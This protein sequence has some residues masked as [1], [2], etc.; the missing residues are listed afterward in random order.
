MSIQL[1]DD[2]AEIVFT[3]CTFGDLVCELLERR[4]QQMRATSAYRRML[5][6][7]H[8]N[9]GVKELHK[10]VDILSQSEKRKLRRIDSVAAMAKF[11][12]SVGYPDILI[13]SSNPEAVLRQLRDLKRQP[14]ISTDQ[15]QLGDVAP[16]L[17]QALPSLFEAIVMLITHA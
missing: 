1:E 5:L 14:Y 6:N 7:T 13:L 2:D 8:G 15:D 3:R 16:H 11:F 10:S 12:Q 9:G 17:I 4:A